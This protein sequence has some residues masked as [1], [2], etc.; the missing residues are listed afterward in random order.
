MG[1]EAG[2]GGEDT[3]RNDGLTVWPCLAKCTQ[4]FSTVCTCSR[5]GDGFL[6]KPLQGLSSG[7]GPGAARAGGGMDSEG[8]RKH[9]KRAWEMLGGLRWNCAWLGSHDPL[10]GGVQVTQLVTLS[11]IRQGASTL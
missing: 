7:S 9:H 10:R 6:W 3:R 5:S 11:H 1:E 2:G 4:A 8:N